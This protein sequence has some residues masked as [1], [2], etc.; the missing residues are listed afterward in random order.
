MPRAAGGGMHGGDAHGHRPAAPTA[1][2]APAG[3]RRFYCPVATGSSVLVIRRSSLMSSQSIA[4]AITGPDADQAL[5][6]LLG[7]AGI[8]GEAEPVTRDENERDAGVLVAFGAIVGIAGGIA[9]LVSGIIEWREKWKRARE[10]RR[11]SVV[12]EDAKGSRVS[13]VDAT[14]EQIAAVLQT[15]RA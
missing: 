6:D 1:I 14:P 4:V 8:Q 10:G 11:L 5:A 12:I 3:A 9:S 13:L 7:I 15:L 2:L